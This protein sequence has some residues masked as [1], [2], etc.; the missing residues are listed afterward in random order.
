MLFTWV[1]SQNCG[2]ILNVAI[3][4][5]NQTKELG[6]LSISSEQVSCAFYLKSLLCDCAEHG[7][8]LVLPDVG[9]NDD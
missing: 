3:K 4:Q 9:D 6:A 5:R 1:L 2:N 7:E 8:V